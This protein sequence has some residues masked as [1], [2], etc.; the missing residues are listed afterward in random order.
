MYRRYLSMNLISTT[1]RLSFAYPHLY[2]NVEY[3]VNN[4]LEAATLASETSGS[5]A[6]DIGRELIATGNA[7]ADSRREPRFQKLV[8]VALRLCGIVQLNAFV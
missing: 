1:F 5:D 2:L 6:K 3:R 4:V 7:L 8:R